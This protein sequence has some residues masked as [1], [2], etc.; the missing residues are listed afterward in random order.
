V[1]AVPARAPAILALD[2]DGVLCDGMR[3]YFESAWRACRRLGAGAPAAPPAGLFES[4][5]RLRPLVETGWE[6]TAVVHAL[7]AGASPAALEKDWRPEAWLADLP[8]TRDAAAA[9][10]DRVRD[11]WIA[12]DERGWLESHRF[13]PGVVAR[14]AGLLAGPVAV[15]VVTTKEGRF[16]RQLLRR[17]GVEL[18]AGRVLG[19]EARRPKRAILRELAAGGDAAR[20][21]FVEDRLPT[22]RDVT[23]EPALAGASLFLAAW[24]YNTPEDREAAR[25]DGRIVLLALD[26]FCGDLARWPAED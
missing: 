19:K 7:H 15:H 17:Q 4:F 26:R 24:G 13:Y 8:A 10:L 25:R 2:F 21:W 20:V 3:E 23:A 5:A 12:A 18:P 11:E 14:L 16:A 22:L 6:M 1:P 9:A